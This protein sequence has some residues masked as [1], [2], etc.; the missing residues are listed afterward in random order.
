MA[1]SLMYLPLMV[2]FA[3]IGAC[4]SQEKQAKDSCVSCLEPDPSC[5]DLETTGCPLE[6]KGTYF[7]DK[8]EQ[9]WICITSGETRT[10]IICGP[11]CDC[12]RRDGL[13]DTASC[14][15]VD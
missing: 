4:G 13:W 9:L 12:L 5:P 15:P 11:T 2:S 7:C 6:K 10:W 1:R 14:P 3:L 8:C